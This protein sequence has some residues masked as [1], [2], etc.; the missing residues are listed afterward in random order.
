MPKKSTLDAPTLAALAVIEFAEGK[1]HYKTADA[2]LQVL[3]AKAKLG[4]VIT[5]PDKSSIVIETDDGTRKLE[6]PEEFRG[7]KFR[8]SHKGYFFSVGQTA[9][10][11]ELV[12]AP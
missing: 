9:R 2:A 12:A 6:I 3:A 10:A 8:L 4:R 5:I 7:K 1:R 11:V